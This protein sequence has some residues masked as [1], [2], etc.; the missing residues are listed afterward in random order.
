MIKAIK[1]FIDDYLVRHRNVVNRILHIIGVPLAF[2]GIY[3]I[4]TGRWQVGLLNLFNGYLLQWIG[5][6][7][8]DKN[9]LGEWILIKKVYKRCTSKTQ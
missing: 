8:F 5:H 3:Q 2:F 4:L 1:A 6:A 9:E 7:V